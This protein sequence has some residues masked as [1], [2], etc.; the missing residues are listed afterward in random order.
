[1]AK[2]YATDYVDFNLV[3]LGDTL[4]FVISNLARTLRRVILLM[5]GGEKRKL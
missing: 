2:G 1:M 5:G 4:F 3:L